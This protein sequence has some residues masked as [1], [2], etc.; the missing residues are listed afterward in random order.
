MV[1]LNIFAFVFFWS[2]LTCVFVKHFLLLFLKHSFCIFCVFVEK[3]FVF[4]QTA[5]A[6]LAKQTALQ[7]SRMRNIENL[8]RERKDNHAAADKLKQALAAAAKAC[9]DRD[10]LCGRNIRCD[11]CNHDCCG[12]AA[13]VA[14]IWL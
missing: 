2:L 1:F 8:E 13:V 9:A 5:K 6:D 7:S 12:R 11:C 10:T 3:V 14:T 4:V